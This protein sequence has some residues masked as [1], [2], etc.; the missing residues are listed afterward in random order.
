MLFRKKI[1]RAC[2]YCCH[3]TKLED[4][5][6]LC[7]KKGVKEADAKCRRFRYDPIKRIPPRARAMDFSRYEEDDF[8]L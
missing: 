3:G 8:S 4:G 7:A 2:S 6:I 1:E 5:M